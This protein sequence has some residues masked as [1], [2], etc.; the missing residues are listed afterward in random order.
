MQLQ[1]V[2]LCWALPLLSTTGL[3]P[4]LLTQ[5]GIALQ[6][7]ENM[8][9]SWGPVEDALCRGRMCPRSWGRSLIYMHDRMDGVGMA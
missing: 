3:C 2:L 6:Q 7:E 4:S 8:R 5:L 1:A 9:G